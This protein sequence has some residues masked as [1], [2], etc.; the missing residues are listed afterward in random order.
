MHQKEGTTWISWYIYKYFVYIFIFTHYILLF[1]DT[2]HPWIV[3][4]ILNV[5]HVFCNSSL[6]QNCSEAS[7]WTKK[8]SGV[9]VVVSRCTPQ[10]CD[11]K[12]TSWWFQ[13]FLFSTLFGEDSHFDVHI[14][15]MGWNHQLDTVRCEIHTMGCFIEI[16]YSTTTGPT[17]AAFGYWSTSDKLCGSY[18]FSH[19]KNPI[20]LEIGWFTADSIDPEVMP[21]MAGFFGIGVTVRSITRAGT[22]K[23]VF[24]VAGWL[25]TGR[26]VAPVPKMKHIQRDAHGGSIMEGQDTLVMNI[27]KP[28]GIL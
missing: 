4:W 11:T 16:R 5:Y 15:Q 2:L 13:T 3:L 21:L 9:S 12:Y 10:P 26:T 22:R 6:F 27:L 7:L 24:N 18:I 23:P 1:L 14:F 28:Q 17:I 25:T 8:P 20:F 19:H